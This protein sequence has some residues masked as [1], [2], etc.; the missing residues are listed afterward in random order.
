MCIVLMIIA[1]L[2]GLS[3]PALHSAMTE[4]TVRR[5]SHQLALMVKTAMIQASEQHRAYAIELTATTMALH[6]V[7]KAAADA[8]ASSDD[9]SSDADTDASGTGTV[10]I[11]MPDVS[12][13]S[14]VDPTNKLLAPDPNKA[15]SWVPVPDGTEWI[16]QPGELCPATV[17][18]V[19]H[20]DAWLQ[21]TFDALTGNVDKETYSFP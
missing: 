9:D 4:Q 1:M 12:V 18:R 13:S 15:D 8:D 6:P 7:G 16:F 20:G 2:F 10:T 11:A 19:G 5:D 17:V 14:D 3:V 21:M